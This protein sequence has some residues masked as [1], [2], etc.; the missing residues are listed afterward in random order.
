[1][2]SVRDPVM[3]S[4]SLARAP[5]NIALIKYMGKKELPGNIPE[6][7]SLSVTLEALC[8]YAEISRA[9][10]AVVT[11]EWIP[12]LPTIPKKDLVGSPVVPALSEKAAERALRHLRAVREAAPKLFSEFGIA[13]NNEVSKWSLRTA[14]T[15]PAASGIASSASSFA[16]ITLST[17]FAM[18]REPAE[19]A[20]NWAKNPA[21]KG[22]L[23]RLARA[24]SGSSC[25][26]LTGP[27]V[28]WEQEDAEPLPVSQAFP[29]L[30]HFVLL[31]SDQEKAV[32]S[33]QA[34][35]LV[36]TSPLW[37][38]RVERV[39]E[40][41]TKM[42]LAFRRGDLDAIARIAWNEA[43]EMHSL[44]HTCSEPFSYWTGDTMALLQWLSPFLSGAKPPIV[45]L[46]AGPN[47]HLLVQAADATEWQERLRASFPAIRLLR[48][49]PG[50][51]AV[52]ISH[53]GPRP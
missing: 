41:L 38:G 26:S 13:P 27:F 9:P 28:L 2:T 45:T 36:K 30:A 46:D 15:F 32:S 16:A 5:S 51:G 24:G 1:M 42:Q 37:I 10:A 29:E 39:Q 48:D 43:W 14:N 35:A 33:S 44:F 25:R 17:A 6:N 23:A 18:A 7:G 50:A 53:K 8:T 49:K 19:F 20:K 34:H 22:A 40:R 4:V 3:T 47:I 21:L 52:A 12:E 11:E 31:V